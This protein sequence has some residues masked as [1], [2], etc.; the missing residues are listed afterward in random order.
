MDPM[1]RM[2]RQR[3]TSLSTSTKTIRISFVRWNMMSEVVLE[4]QAGSTV[5]LEMAVLE[6]EAVHPLPGKEYRRCRH[7]LQG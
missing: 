1:G 6:A 5:N 7:L 3:E 2:A 4:A